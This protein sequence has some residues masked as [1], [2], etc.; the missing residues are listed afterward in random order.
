[1]KKI[2]GL[3]DGEIFFVKMED[4]TPHLGCNRIPVYDVIRHVDRD[5]M[6]YLQTDPE[7]VRDLWVEAVRTGYTDDGLTDYFEQLVDDSFDESIWDGEAW[8]YKDESDCDSL[9]DDYRKAADE[10]LET[11]KG[12]EVGSW[13]SSGAYPPPSMDFDILFC[14]PEF[15]ERLKEIHSK[16]KEK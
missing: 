10:W 12:I 6:R 11:N 13:E 7:S 5:T 16:S 9:T 2:V 8:P 1:M 3:L 4:G 15:L 14:E